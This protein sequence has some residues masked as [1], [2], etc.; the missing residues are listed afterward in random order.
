MARFSHSFPLLA[1]VVLLLTHAT[2][3]GQSLDFDPDYKPFYHGVASG[4]PLADR[5][6]IWTRVTPETSPMAPVDVHWQV[7]TDSGMTHVVQSGVF[8]TDAERDYTVKVDVTDLAP[9][10]TYY[11]HFSALNATSITGR[12]RT[13]PTADEA[14]RLRFAVVSCSNYQAGYFSAY[15]KIAERADLD[16]VIHLGDYIYEYSA[17]G[18]DFYGNED[19]RQNRSHL[20]DKEIVTLD[21]Y[22]TRY[23]QYR[24]DP[25]LRAVHQQHPFIAVWDDHESTNDSYEDGAQN[26]QSETEGPWEERKSESKQGVRG[27]ATYSG[28]FGRETPV[29]EYPLR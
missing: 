5:V 12:T 6:I 26:H 11:Y 24:L 14:D 22:R 10:T 28:R 8:T 21:D 27:V 29:S 23:S 4:D 20:P 7:A 1:G 13:A 16:A 17:S 2:S 3:V 19:L 25:D 18:E 9:Y 15:R